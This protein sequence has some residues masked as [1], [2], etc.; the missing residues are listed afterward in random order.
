MPQLPKCLAVE[1]IES[2]AS[3]SSDIPRDIAELY[4]TFYLKYLETQLLLT[5]SRLGNSNLH[6]K[7]LVT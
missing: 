5:D 2:L 7:R 3:E 6:P 4:L 1:C